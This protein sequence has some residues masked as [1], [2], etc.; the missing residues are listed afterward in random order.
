[1][2][3]MISNIPRVLLEEIFL[4][5]PL[6][7]LRAVRL[8]CKSWNSLTKSESFRNMYISKAATREEEE[9]MMIALMDYNLCFMKVIVD[10]VDSSIEF[11]KRKP[12]FLEEQVKVSRVFHCDGLLLCILEDPS[13]VV[14]LNPYLGETRWIKLR[15]SHSLYGLQRFSYGLGYENKNSCRSVKLLRFLD[16]C[17]V[18]NESVLIFS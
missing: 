4:T 6:K 10:D 9:S 18:I 13:D 8:T 3:T 16:L 15:Y 2:T 12:S 14:V 5:L 17:F 11:I 7:S 1:M